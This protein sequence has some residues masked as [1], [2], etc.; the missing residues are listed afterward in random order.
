L[1]AR[2]EDIPLLAQ[3]FARH[4]ARRMNKSIEGISIETMDAL[5]R[6]TWPGNIRELQNV[7]ERAVVFYANGNLSIKKSWLSRDWPHNEQIQSSAI[8]TSAMSDREIIR[9]V[10]AETK[11]RVSGPFGAATKLGMPAST[12]ESKIKSMNINK[13]S[14]KTAG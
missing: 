12:L 14:F 1:R 10:L 6:Y 9:G 3:Y 11:G 13:H 8:K 7:I 5:S 4:F 2:P